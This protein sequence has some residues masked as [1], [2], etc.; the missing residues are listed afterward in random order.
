MIVNRI[1]FTIIWSHD[2]TN[3]ANQ[4][5]GLKKGLKN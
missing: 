2:L 5:T 1:N 4:N 3:K